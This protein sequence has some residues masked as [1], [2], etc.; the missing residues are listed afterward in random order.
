VSLTN[1]A[2][3]PLLKGVNLRWLDWMRFREG[4]ALEPAILY[5]NCAECPADTYLTTFHFDMA[6]HAWAA[7]WM[8]GDEGVPL[9]SAN[10]PPG[11]TMTGVYAAMAEP[12][13]NEY[14][15]TWKHFDYGT[16]KPAEDI[17]YRYDLDS[18]RSLER[19]Q[20][21]NGKDAEAMKQRL[22]S[23]PGAVAGLARG[24][25]SSLCVQTAKP[26]AERKPVTTPPANNRGQSAPPGARH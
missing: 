22:C 15:G 3:T 1:H 21:L 2:V 16:E 25:D 10:P 9:W 6:Q 13:G 23:G 18:F 11:V 12:N 7:R 19:T 17:V 20:M 26:R 5:D 24:Q 8:R 4:A 14:V